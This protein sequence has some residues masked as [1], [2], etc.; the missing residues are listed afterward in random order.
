MD[1]KRTPIEA[2]DIPD[3]MA[4]FPDRAEGPNRYVVPIEKII[5]N[6][7]SLAAGRYKPVTVEIVHHD[8]PAKA[9]NDVIAL[10]HEISLRA[11]ELLSH[12]NAKTQA[13]PEP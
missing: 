2:N 4:K 8:A 10:E 3:V 9:I 12:L 11:K 6:E 7:Y 1:D 5:E 13:P